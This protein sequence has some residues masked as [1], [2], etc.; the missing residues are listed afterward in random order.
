MVRA[1][2][3][4]V[5]QVSVVI[6]HHTGRL[7]DRCLDSVF[8]SED[9]SYEVLVLTSDPTYEN[10]AVRM[11]CEGGPAHKRNVG[12]R[13]S[14]APYVVFLDDDVEISPYCLYEFCRWMEEHPRCGM[15]FARIYNAERRTELDDAGSFLTFTGFLWARA[16]SQIDIGQ[17]AI[18]CHVL[19]SKSA[20]CVVRR[21]AFCQVGGFDKDYY[22]LAEDSLLAYTLWLQG[23]ECWYVPS[24]KSWHWFNTSLKPKEQY[25]TNHRIFFLGSRNYLWML[26]SC[27]GLSRLLVILPI[28]V[29]IW[30]IAGCGF[31]LKGEFQRGYFILRGIWTSLCSPLTYRKRTLVQSQRICSD[32]ELFSYIFSSPPLRYYFTRL[33]RYITQALHG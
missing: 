30:H 14:K 20:T 19:A 26:I 11:W 21:S 13:H 5:P 18:P 22:I 23:W 28:H 3:A 15:A 2:T 17:Y 32:K 10:H 9:V 33:S 12:V 31:I 29:L 4:E 7:I 8:K 1:Q 24:A 27:V 16:N 25:Y 6:C